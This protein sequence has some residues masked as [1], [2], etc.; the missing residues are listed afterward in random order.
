MQVAPQGGFTTT[1]TPYCHPFPSTSLFFKGLYRPIIRVS[2]QR[3]CKDKSLSMYALSAKHEQ[4]F[5][6]SIL[7]AVI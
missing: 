4:A 1:F 3:D 7:G 2:P 6:W 5:L